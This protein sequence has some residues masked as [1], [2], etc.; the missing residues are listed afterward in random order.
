MRIKWNQK[1]R[2]GLTLI[3]LAV[4]VLILG[5]IIALVAFNINPGQ[6]KDDTAALKLKKDSSAI[7]SYLEMYSAKYGTYP[8][9]EQGL[10]A[11]YEKPTVGDVPQ[12]FK[13]IVKD[14]S[15]VEDPWGTIYQIKK[16]SSGDYKIMTLGKDKKPGGTG[17]DADFDINNESEYPADFKK[18]AN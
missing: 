5:S 1:F 10:K 2:K 13:P 18:K 3:E 12:D 11:L 15:A 9:E 4:V 6:L 8:T 16:D 14:K 17:K 7:R